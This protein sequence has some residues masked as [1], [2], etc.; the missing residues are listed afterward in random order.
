MTATLNT[1]MMGYKQIELMKKIDFQWEAKI[2][3]SGKTIFVYEDE[4]EKE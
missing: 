2:I 3:G 4:F 1:P